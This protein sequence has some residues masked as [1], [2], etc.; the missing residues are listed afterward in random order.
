[1]QTLTAPYANLLYNAIADAQ[2]KGHLCALI[3]YQG[4]IDPKTMTERG[5]NLDTL[6][7][8]SIFQGCTSDD[9]DSVRAALIESGALDLLAVL[10]NR[11]EPQ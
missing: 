9:L 10:T 7:I 1:M 3:D 6:Y 2:H 5:V 8:A 11:G 4:M